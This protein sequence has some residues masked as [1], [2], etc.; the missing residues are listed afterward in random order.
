MASLW[1]STNTRDW[2][3]ALERYVEVVERQGVARLGELDGWYREMLPGAIRERTPPHVT[4]DE[5]ARLTEWKMARGVWRAR[6][7]A[8]VRGNDPALVIATSSGALKE[9]PDPA[10]PIAMLA[11][12]NGVGPATASAVASAFAPDTY[13]FFDELVARQIPGAGPVTF[14]PAYY[15]RYADAIRTRA[16]ELGDGWT[17]VM[18]ER[19]LWSHSG[20]KAALRAAR[21]G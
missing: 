5:L 4:L 20:G 11:S 7:L 2:A 9:V 8:L 18:L 12:L 16:R 6:N 13:P 17:P 3:A 14:T 1:S 19:A 10:K 21:G 15:R